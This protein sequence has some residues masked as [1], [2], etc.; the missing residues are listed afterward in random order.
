MLSPGMP[1]SRR[2]RREQWHQLE[3]QGPALAAAWGRRQGW[4]AALGRLERWLRQVPARLG[5]LR[6]GLSV[7]LLGPDGAGKS[8]LVAGLTH[9]FVTDARIIYLGFGISGG[10]SRPPLLARLRLPVLGAPGRLLVLWDRFLR[11]CFHQTRGRL[12]LF[13]RYTFDALAPPPGR[14]SWLRRIS[15]W[16]KARA[17]PV[18]D[19]VVVLDVPGTVMFQ[20]K[21][22]TFH[23]VGAG[24]CPDC[25]DRSLEGRARAGR[26]RQTGVPPAAHRQREGAIRL[27]RGLAHL[28]PSCWPGR[29]VVAVAPR[30]RRRGRLQGPGP[31]TRRTTGA[32]LNRTS[33][34]S[35][36]GSRPDP[37]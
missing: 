29:G 2:V 6:R 28:L 7:A 8:T 10:Q 25:P 32:W 26:A 5:C 1:D 11:A 37:C 33:Q 4:N 15:P 3:Q 9:A 31:R 21:A 35:G 20:P 22:I 19:L 18:P 17:C 13:D 36:G 16:I 34:L 30:G 12:V 14:C 24:A 27:V 23:P